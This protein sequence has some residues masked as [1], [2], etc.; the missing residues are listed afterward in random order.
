MGIGKEKRKRELI[1]KMRKRSSVCVSVVVVVCVCVCCVCL[2]VCTRVSVCA[3]V[4]QCVSVCVSVCL[5]VCVSVCKRVHEFTNKM[6]QCVHRHKSVYTRVCMKHSRS[7]THTYTH[8]HTPPPP[9]SIHAACSLSWPTNP[10]S[11]ML[12]AVNLFF[13]N[14]LHN[15]H[16][17]YRSRSRDLFRS[18]QYVFFRVICIPNSHTHTHTQTQTQTQTKTHTLPGR[19]LHWQE[20]ENTQCTC[21]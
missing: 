2:C 5:S 11:L 16:I 9:S 4:C 3:S 21:L 19:R 12:A 17:S 1:C 15:K 18:L 10:G 20:Q 14:T 7:L 8:T 13:T 6:S